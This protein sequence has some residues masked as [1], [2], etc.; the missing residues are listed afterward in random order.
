MALWVDTSDPGKLMA[1]RFAQSVWGEP[2]RLSGATTV[3]VLETAPALVFDGQSFVAAWTAK[4]SGK[5]Y[6]YTARYDLKA[7]W[8]SS[9]KQQAAAD[10]TSAAVM[11]A[12]VSD[13]RGNLLLVFAKGADPTYSLAYQRYSAHTW[14]PITAVPGGTITNQ[15]FEG[16]GGLRLSMSSNGLAALAWTNYDAVKYVSAV[17]LASFY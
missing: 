10:G 5:R 7:G 14:G 4:D 3:D 15:A 1:S 6:T 13:G 12:L 16:L 17:R 9:E 8:E 2:V 11:P